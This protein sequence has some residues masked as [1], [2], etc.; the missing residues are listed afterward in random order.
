V[1]TN[2][3]ILARV[4]NYGD[5]SANNVLV[6]FFD[7]STEI[8]SVGSRSINPNGSATI[9]IRTTF[10]TMG[11]HIVWV[12]VD[13]NGQIQEEDEDNNNASRSIEVLDHPDLQ[14]SGL[15]FTALGVEVAE[16]NGLTWVNITATVFNGAATPVSNP[17]IT[18]WI[19]V[20][21]GDS[22]M[23]QI[24]VPGEF[25]YAA[26][27]A[28][29]LAEYRAPRFDHQQNVTVTMVVNQAHLVQETNYSNN[30]V[31]R[32]LIIKDDRPDLSVSSA[33]VSVSKAGVDIQS[34][35]FGSAV[36]VMVLVKNLGGRETTFKMTVRLS[37][38]AG[39]NFTI[40]D[41]P[42]TTYRPTPRTT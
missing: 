27:T 36:S 26:V 10:D 13:P 17:V 37:D 12:R 38:N 4:W 9:S 3:T 22:Q 29:V 8:G 24:T 1:D 16:V 11:S 20:S 7:G 30:V 2:I 28:T 32:V 25:A 14:L 34:D 23:S 21:G 5:L 33:D 39:Y 40:L 15:R 19:N 18:L 42:A 35:T 6:K 31:S 41:K